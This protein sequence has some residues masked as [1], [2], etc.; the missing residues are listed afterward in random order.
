MGGRSAWAGLRGAWVGCCSKYGLTIPFK[1]KDIRDSREIPFLEPASFT[2]IFHSA[3]TMRTQYG[4]AHSITKHP[5]MKFPTNF[6]Q[7][8]TCNFRS[9]KCLTPGTHP[10]FPA[11][12]VGTRDGPQ[13][14]FHSKGVSL[15]TTFTQNYFRT[16]GTSLFIR[17][18]NTLLTNIL[19]QRL[20][21][22]IHSIAVSTPLALAVNTIDPP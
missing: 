15:K 4:D 20:S 5:R 11:F 8:S 22:P 14:G 2:P 17:N 1:E 19:I 12:H 18:T 21:S 10:P 16:K 13:K 6:F 7:L 3:H 9:A